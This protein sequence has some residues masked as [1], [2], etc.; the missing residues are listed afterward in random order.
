MIYRNL[1]LLM[2][3]YAP[4][5][6]SEP[7]PDAIE[8]PPNPVGGYEALVA[9]IE[10]PETARLAGVEGTVIVNVYV[11]ELGQVTQTVVLQGVRRTGLDEAALAGIRKTRFTPAHQDSVALGMWIAIPVTF[12]L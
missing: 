3:V 12:R 5:A 6:A 11:N 1:L 7:L 8:T 10:Y 4:L 2:L 9:N